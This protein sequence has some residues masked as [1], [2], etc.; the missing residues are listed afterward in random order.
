[1]SV[2]R[3]AVQTFISYGSKVFLNAVEL[4]P[5]IDVILAHEGDQEAI[6]RIEEINARNLER[7]TLT[8]KNKKV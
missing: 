4:I 3:S 6:K 5:T 2:E 7:T 1:M 8:T